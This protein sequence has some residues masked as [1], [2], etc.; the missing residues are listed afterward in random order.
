MGTLIRQQDFRCSDDCARSGCQGHTL[1][2]NVQTTSDIMDV[3]IDGETLFT[4]DPAKW[5]ALL[6][7]VD[8]LDYVFFKVKK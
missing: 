8:S 5:D 7:A 4:T 1:Q 6:K 3:L 2:V